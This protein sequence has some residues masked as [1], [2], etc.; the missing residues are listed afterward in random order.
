MATVKTAGGLIPGTVDTPLDARSR[1]S[2]E[3]EIMNIEN[4]VLGALV[5]CSEN[6]KYYKITALKSKQ[7]G[8]LT[9]ENAAVAE[10]EELQSGGSGTVKSVNGQLPDESGNV[11]VETG[12]AVDESRLLPENP[13]NG[14][15]PCFDATATIGGGNDANTRILL[16]FDAD[17]IKDEAAGNAAPVTI[18]KKTGTITVVE[19]GKWGK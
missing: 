8:P 17:E 6:G 11:T 19:G 18:T 4:P 12:G 15:I 9:V 3:A 7:I 13:A 14:D 5:F 1:V 16:H 2:A 10:Y